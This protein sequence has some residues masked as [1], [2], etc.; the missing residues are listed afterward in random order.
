MPVTFSFSDV[1][2]TEITTKTGEFDVRKLVVRATT[3]TEM[4]NVITYYFAT[5]LGISVVQETKTVMPNLETETHAEVSELPQRSEVIT[6]DHPPHPG[7][8]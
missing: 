1:G 6:S 5:D 8:T 4:T 7:D 2:D 3:A